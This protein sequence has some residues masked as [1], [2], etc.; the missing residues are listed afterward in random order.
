MTLVYCVCGKLQMLFLLTVISF[1]FFSNGLA[2]LICDNSCFRFNMNIYS[3]IHP[4][5]QQ[6]P[7][8]S[9][10]TLLVMVRSQ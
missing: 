9:T 5:L 10:S 6:I 7:A 2:L 1:I 8:N 4:S 3:Q